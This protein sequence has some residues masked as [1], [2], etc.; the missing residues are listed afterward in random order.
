MT[1]L[2]AVSTHGLSEGRD[3]RLDSNDRFRFCL[4]RLMGRS[5]VSLY[6]AKEEEEFPEIFLSLVE[7]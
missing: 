4:R 3:I 5:V 1:F 7:I 2:V 6:H